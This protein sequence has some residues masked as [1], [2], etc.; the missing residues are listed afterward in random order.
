MA[1][2]LDGIEASALG[3]A[4]IDV[5]RLRAILDD[6]PADAAAAERHYVRLMHTLGR[7]LAVGGFIRWAEGSNL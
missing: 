1:A 5:P 2:E 6:W 3:R 4:L 7:G